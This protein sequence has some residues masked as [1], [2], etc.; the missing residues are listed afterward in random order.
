MRKYALMLYKSDLNTVVFMRFGFNL[1]DGLDHLINSILLL[2]AGSS[3]DL[4]NLGIGLLVNL[5][6]A[7]I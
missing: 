3:T 7:L 2:V 6:K 4:L 1:S 5:T